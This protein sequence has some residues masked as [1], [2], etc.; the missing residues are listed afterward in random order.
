MDAESPGKQYRLMVLGNGSVRTIPLEGDQWVIGRSHECSIALRDPTVSRRH[1]HLERRDGRFFFRDLG[2]SNPVVLDGRPMSHGELAVGQSLAIGLTRL[3]LEPRA[4]KVPSGPGTIVLG[5][6]V[7]D[8]ASGHADGTF[9]AAASQLLEHLALTFADLGS[10]AEAAE[11]LLELTLALTGRR[12]GALLRFTA[13]GSPEDIDGTETLAT[14]EPGDTDTS[15]GLPEVVRREARKLDQP[16]VLQVRDG[17][18]VQHWLIVPLGTGP[19]GVIAAEGAK[20]EAAPDQ[21]VLQLCAPL[22]KLIWH[23]LEETAERLRLRDE[24]Q[25]LRGQGTAAFQAMLASNRLHAARQQL[26]IHAADDAALLFVGEIGTERDVLARYLH[27]ESPRARL[28]FL[29]VDAAALEDWR[30]DR[31]LFGDGN[32]VGAIQRVVGGT[33]FID[34]IERLGPHR[35]QRLVDALAALDADSRPRLVAAAAAAPGDATVPWSDALADL[36]E[37]RQVVVPALRADARDVLT[38]A[39]VF[40]AEMGPGPGGTPRLL[41]ERA[42]HLLAGYPWPGNVR[43]LRR[44]VDSAA[45]EAGADP[46]APR[47][48]PTELADGGE[49]KVALPTLADV[50]RQHIVEVLRHSGGNRTRAAQALGIA[51][52]TLYEKLKRHAIDD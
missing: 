1:V 43:E 6:E 23:R 36:F 2:G 50:E 14:I 7:A 39:Q 34:N 20:P 27:H 47:H 45:A 25:Q 16:H 4:K 21:D 46:I 26:R 51:T 33:L 35:Q 48:L 30:G 18:V 13:N 44:V 28:P 22:A 32:R 5:R 49:T 17:D 12:R 31:E 41:S 15:R 52:S 10:L 24:A 11:P 37:D 19:R 8:N 3:T 38:L 9:L 40:L 29:I 42:K